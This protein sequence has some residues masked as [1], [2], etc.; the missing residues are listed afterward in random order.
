MGRDEGLDEE[1]S[2]EVMREVGRWRR[3][4]Q[5]PFPRVSPADRERLEGT[6]DYPPRGSPDALHPE[7]LEAEMA[8][9]LSREPESETETEEEEKK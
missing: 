5:L 4:G 1:R 3:T 9:P 7:E 8:E 6:L 2:A